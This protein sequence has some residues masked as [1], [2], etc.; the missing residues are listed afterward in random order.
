MDISKLNA[1]EAYAASRTATGSGLEHVAQ[2]ASQAMGD[3]V[4]TLQEGERNAIASTNSVAEPHAFV[5]ALVQTELAVQTTVAVRDRV[6][7]AYQEILR[8]PV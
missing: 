6:I 3:F 8:M 4:Q 1:L 2:S 5:E 7:E